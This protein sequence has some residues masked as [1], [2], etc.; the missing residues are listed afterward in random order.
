MR[1]LTL[2]RPKPLMPIVDKPVTQHI[3]DHLIEHGVTEVAF[4]TNYLREQI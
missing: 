2:S 1:P 3:L 4:T